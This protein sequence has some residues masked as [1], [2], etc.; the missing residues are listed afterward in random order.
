MYM[1]VYS[2]SVDELTK[3]YL[4]TMKKGSQLEKRNTIRAALKET[5]VLGK[6]LT[7]RW[8]QVTKH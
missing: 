5:T 4:V 3:N 2:Q 8:K 6:I 7:D 1:S